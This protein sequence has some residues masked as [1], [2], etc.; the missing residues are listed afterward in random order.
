MKLTI[1]LR[2]IGTSRVSEECIPLVARIPDGR[3]GF[4]SDLLERTG[5]TDVEGAKAHL[6][7]LLDNRFRRP[8]EITWAD[9]T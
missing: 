5:L 6:Q 7:Q 3:G 1:E 8:V 2:R 9:R 4:G